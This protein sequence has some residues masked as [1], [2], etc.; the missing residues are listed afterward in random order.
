M[1]PQ[2]ALYG[3]MCD[4]VNTAKETTREGL[5]TKAVELQDY[6]LENLMSELAKAM[7][8]ITQNKPDDPL[9]ALANHLEKVGMEQEE[10][11]RK[12][13]EVRFYELLAKSEA[14]ET[15]FDE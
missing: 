1:A 14:G 2:L 9:M 13:A 15:T 6:L 5:V 11:A 3:E 7:I 12:K 4:I 10:E 8:D